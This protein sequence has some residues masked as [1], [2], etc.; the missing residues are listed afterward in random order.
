M[1]KAQEAHEVISI[2]S[3]HLLME[4]YPEALVRALEETVEAFYDVKRDEHGSYN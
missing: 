2:L 1:T 3:E 4:D